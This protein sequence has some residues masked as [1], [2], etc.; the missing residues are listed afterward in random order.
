MVIEQ[1]PDIDTPDIDT[2]VSDI[3][4]HAVRH[5]PGCAF[6]FDAG[7]QTGEQTGEKV[8]LV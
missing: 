1:S 3:F 5:S 4:G 6:A 7:F 8:S 2:K